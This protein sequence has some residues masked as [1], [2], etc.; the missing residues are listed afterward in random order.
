MEK[1]LYERRREVLAERDALVVAMGG[2]RDYFVATFAEELPARWDWAARDWFQAHSDVMVSHDQS[3][4][5]LQ[6]ESLDRRARET[7]NATLAGSHVWG[8]EGTEDEIWRKRP[9]SED[10]NSRWTHVS[11]AMSR[12][13]QV[14][15]P[16]LEDHFGENGGVP[17]YDG[18]AVSGALVNILEIYAQAFDRLQ[19]VARAISRLNGQ[20]SEAE[21]AVVRA[22]RWK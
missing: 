12:A 9:Y 5:R 17:D 18:G 11:E 15:F 13:E 3:G 4:L 22:E 10:G 14:V 2:L 6:L 7:A 20:I 21:A 8:H 1:D 19:K 16:V